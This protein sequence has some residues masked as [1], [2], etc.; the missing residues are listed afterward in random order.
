MKN[1]QLILKYVCVDA[2]NK[3][4]IIKANMVSSSAH[5]IYYKVTKKLDWG[6][7]IAQ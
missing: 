2:E 6:G 5:Q 7:E 1:D 3:N 4:Y